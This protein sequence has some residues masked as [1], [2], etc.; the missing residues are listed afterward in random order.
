MEC[1]E[2][3]LCSLTN[4]RSRRTNNVNILE[5]TI[6]NCFDKYHIRWV[7]QK[8]AINY[9]YYNG[10]LKSWNLFIYDLKLFIYDSS[11]LMYD[12]N[13]FMYVETY[14]CMK[15]THLYILR[16]IY[17]RSGAIYVWSGRIYIWLIRKIKI[18]YIRLIS[19][20]SRRTRI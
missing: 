10:K 12:N 5:P 16:P 7:I 11:L 1:V 15:E 18:N 6:V 19:T 3:W 17:V 8:A 9:C 20:P 4:P 14:L 2:W 13:L